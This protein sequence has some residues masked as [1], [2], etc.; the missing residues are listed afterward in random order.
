MKLK[1]F[2][3]ILGKK[4][5]IFKLEL[6]PQNFHYDVLYPLYSVYNSALQL[7]YYQKGSYAS[8]W[9]PCYGFQPGWPIFACS[10]AKM[11]TRNENTRQFWW[12]TSRSVVLMYRED[13]K[14]CPFKICNYRGPPLLSTTWKRSYYENTRQSRSVASQF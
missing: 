11:P 1:N 13:C 9:L 14:N 5:M 6:S 8:K 7:R 2:F 4:I 3:L 12:S 10:G